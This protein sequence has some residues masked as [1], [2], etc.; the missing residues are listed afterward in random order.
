MELIIVVILSVTQLSG[1]SEA[2]LAWV[3]RG[4]TALQP[5]WKGH[6]SNPPTTVPCVR[7]CRGRL[8]CTRRGDRASSCMYIHPRRDMQ[9]EREKKEKEKEATPPLITWLNCAPCGVSL[10]VKYFHKPK[11]TLHLSYMHQ[12]LPADHQITAST[13]F[14]NPLQT[15]PSF[16]SNLGTP[17]WSSRL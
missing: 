14:C 7:Q 16:L 2:A 3:V 15:P 11:Q 12:C 4:S 1:H 6:R 10:L 13:L 17:L 9:S 5:K 8:S